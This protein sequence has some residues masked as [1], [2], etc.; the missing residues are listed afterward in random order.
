MPTSLT[1][2]RN[3]SDLLPRLWEQFPTKLP[4]PSFT[5]FCIPSSAQ[6]RLPLLSKKK[7]RKRCCT[8]VSPN[9]VKCFT[10]DLKPGYWQDQKYR[11]RPGRPIYPKK[12]GGIFT[13]NWYE[14]N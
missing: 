12:I 10:T 9:R 13:E 14:K 3:T 6:N 7:S 4:L 8:T 1:L 5:R 11:R 2:I